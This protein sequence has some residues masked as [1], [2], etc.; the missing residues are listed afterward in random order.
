[1][2]IYIS[3]DESF[4]IILETNSPCITNT[5]ITD[6][7]RCPSP[8]QTRDTGRGQQYGNPASSSSERQPHAT[9]HLHD[10]REREKQTARSGPLTHPTHSC[11]WEQ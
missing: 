5:A 8:W 10:P 11:R 9:I 1:M 4:C 2:Y 3:L 7:S 6:H